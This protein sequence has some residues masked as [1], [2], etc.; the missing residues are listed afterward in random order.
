MWERTQIGRVADPVNSSPFLKNGM[1]PRGN[2]SN[3]GRTD[4]I[5]KMGEKT[6]GLPTL[7]IILLCRGERLVEVVLV[8]VVSVSWEEEREEEVWGRVVSVGWE[9][10]ERDKEVWDRVVSVCPG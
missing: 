4:R 10:E 8:W 2:D 9:E 5:F 6:T 7:S 1:G 3:K